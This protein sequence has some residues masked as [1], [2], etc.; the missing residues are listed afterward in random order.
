MKTGPLYGILAKSKTRM[1]CVFCGVYIPKANKCI[2]EHTNGTKHKENI[3]QMAENGMIYNN[4]Q[5]YCK[6]CN[7]NL[8]EEDSVASHIE[9]DDHANWMAAVDNL[10]EGEFINVDSYLASE[11]EDVYCEVCNCNINCSLQNIETH[12]NDILHRSNVAEKLKPLNGIFRVDN[13][14]EL[15]CKLCDEYIE[16]TARS[17]L[18]HIDDSP[19]HM[20]WFIHIEDLIDG[21]EVSIQDFLKNEHEKNAFCNKCQVEIICNARSIE[22]HVHSEAHLNQFS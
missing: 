8:S 6:P 7:V 15:W 11:S 4:E 16:N 9:S 3:D 20:E 21:Q 17:V 5:L 10:I 19:E 22:D 14:D 13:D 12:V 1:R 18:E 2:E